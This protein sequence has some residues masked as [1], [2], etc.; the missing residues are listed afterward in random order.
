MKDPPKLINYGP[1]Y[2]PDLIHFTNDVEENP[3]ITVS[4]IDHNKTVH[5]LKR[6][7]DS[8]IQS[9]DVNKSKVTETNNSVNAVKNMQHLN[10]LRLVS[11]V[12]LT[13]H[14]K[15]CIW[16]HCVW[17]KPCFWCFYHTS[18]CTGW[19]GVW[20]T[21]FTTVFKWWL[22]QTKKVYFCLLSTDLQEGS[23]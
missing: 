20:Y 2:I 13:S 23:H 9:G 4:N 5:V 19:Y 8:H 3:G 16:S 17:H 11:G 1:F 12:S 15:H 21:L 10:K 6:K 18:I 14:L 7:L 22:C